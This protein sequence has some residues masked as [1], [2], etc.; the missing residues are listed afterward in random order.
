MKLVIFGCGKIAKRIA[1]SCL[2]VNNI[3]LVGFASKDIK[4]ARAYAEEYGCRDYDGRRTH[5]RSGSH[6]HTIRAI[7]I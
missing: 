2:L 3:D 5:G 6:Q 7:L 4:R 1:K